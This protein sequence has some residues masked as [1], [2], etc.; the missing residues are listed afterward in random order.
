MTFKLVMKIIVKYGGRREGFCQFEHKAGVSHV[1]H[2]IVNS[3][4]ALKGVKWKLGISKE[5]IF[6]PD[7]WVEEEPLLLA[8]NFP[9]PKEI[10]GQK[11]AEL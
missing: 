9:V 11:V 3:P 4:E 5:I 7:V 1:Q 10:K 6:W 8:A 2:E